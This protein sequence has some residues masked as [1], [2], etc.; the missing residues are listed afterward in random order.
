MQAG[1]WETVGSV[2]SWLALLLA[3]ILLTAAWVTCKHKKTF[4]AYVFNRCGHLLYGLL[5]GF[6]LGAALLF[7]FAFD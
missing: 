1:L 6:Y 3:A 5:V 7:V 2:N 4:F